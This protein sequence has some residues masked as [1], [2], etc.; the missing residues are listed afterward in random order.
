MIIK[1]RKIPKALVS[2]VLCLSLVVLAVPSLGSVAQAQ[3][4][5]DTSGNASTTMGTSTTN[6]TNTG[7]STDANMMTSMST[8]TSTSTGST[9]SSTSSM[10]VITNVM[11]SSSVDGMSATI[12]WTTDIG[13]TSQ[14]AF[15]M[16][17]GVA[18]GTASSTM[19]MGSTTASTTGMMYSAYSAINSSMTTNHSLTL[20]NLMPNTQ[21]H[22]Q[23][24]S[25]DQS[26]N[27]S[28]S[29]DQT[30]M[31][32]SMGMGSG[33]GT[34]S[35]SS[36]STSTSTGMGTGSTG[37]TT[38]STTDTTGNGGSTSTTT[39]SSTLTLQQLEDQI[40]LLQQQIAILQGQ[41]QMILGSS[42]IGNGGNGGT[43]NGSSTTGFHPAQPSQLTMIEPAS[44]T[45]Q[46][47]SSV[48]FGGRN[49]AADEPVMVTLNGQWV[50]NARADG[51]GNFTT[52]S[53]RM[54]TTSGIY[55][56]TIRGLNS[57]I[58]LQSTI[59]VQ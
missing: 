37:T 9:G 30:F 20:W 4:T 48:D 13:A 45:I 50:A 40:I 27:V 18:T 1:H 42:T 49:F 56:Y 53:V 31:T 12:T 7:T 24:I 34:G 11:A 16:M 46:P 43:G 54:P 59:V 3:T 55:V 26:G 58:S 35:T 15:G 22:Y 25:V 32:T 29:P 23:V 28:M 14:V 47:G 2:G 38:G 52:G 41:V 8:T 57:G 6:T 44:R 36:T 5:T 17:N 51:G 10:P 39:S 33:T 21:Y 19:G